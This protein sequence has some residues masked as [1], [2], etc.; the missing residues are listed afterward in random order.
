[1]QHA[2]TCWLPLVLLDIT[3]EGSCLR[4]TRWKHVNTQTLHY[5]GYNVN[6]LRR[7]AGSDSLLTRE[8]TSGG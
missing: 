7:N 6:L 4:P 1:M 3:G 2:Q 5:W 8:L